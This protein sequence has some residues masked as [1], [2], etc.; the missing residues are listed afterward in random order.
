MQFSPWRKERPQLHMTLGGVLDR[1]S[2]VTDNEVV[3]T[4]ARAIGLG[5][6]IA[7]LLLGLIAILTSDFNW[8][9]DTVPSIVNGVPVAVTY[10]ECFGPSLRWNNG[11][12][13][14][15]FVDDANKGVIGATANGWRSIFT[16]VLHWT[17]L[18]HVKI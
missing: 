15:G 13:G 1:W 18:P 17:I 4:L 2:F 7:T 8:C 16:Y 5:L 10:N 9:P 11:G 3:L 12:T 6:G 14:Q